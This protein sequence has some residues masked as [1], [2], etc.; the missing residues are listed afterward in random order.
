MPVQNLI[1]LDKTGITAAMKGVHNIFLVGLMGAGKTTVGR[2]LA[3]ALRLPFEDSDRAIE[4]RTGVSIPVIFEREGEAGFRS[5]EK[6]IIDELTAKKG[7]ILA[8]GGGVVLDADNRACLRARGCVVYLRAPVEILVN[9][10]THD[11]TH[12]RPLLQGVD[13]RARLCQLLEVRDPLY[14]EVADVILDTSNRSI[15]IVTRE[16]LRQVSR[17][18]PSTSSPPPSVDP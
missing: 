3:R 15:R 10:T 12:K 2:Q 13:A 5:R 7:L 6:A 16:L 8:T 14:R 9:R 1:S 17:Y 4:A 11:R 18:S